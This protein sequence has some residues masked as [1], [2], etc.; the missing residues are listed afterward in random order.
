MGDLVQ[1]RIKRCDCH[2][3]GHTPHEDVESG[4]QYTEVTIDQDLEQKTINKQHNGNE[5]EALQS[6]PVLY[7]VVGYN[8]VLPMCVEMAVRTMRAAEVVLVESAQMHAEVIPS[9]HSSE[10]VRLPYSEIHAASIKAKKKAIVQRRKG[11]A[12]RAE[13]RCS[14]MSPPTP[15]IPEASS[16]GGRG[17]KSKPKS[18]IQQPCSPLMSLRQEQQKRAEREQE[19]PPSATYFPIPVGEAPRDDVQTIPRTARPGSHPS[20]DAIDALPEDINAEEAIVNKALLTEEGGGGRRGHNT[21]QFEVQ[22]V[23][24]WTIHCKGLLQR[25]AAYLV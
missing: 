25:F 12:R 20:R 17:E 8:D 1:V 6:T 11:N 14:V 9:S 22:L 15:T 21:V 4:R 19:S 5:F 16:S 10:D 18:V 2:G 3:P 7:E 23:N 13:N 24:F